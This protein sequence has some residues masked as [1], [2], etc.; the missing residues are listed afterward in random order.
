MTLRSLL[1]DFNS[2]FASVEQQAEPRLRGRPVGVVP[3][4]ADTTVCIAASIEAKTFGVKTGTRVGE[5]KR[6]CP[7]IELV[8]ARHALYIDYHH[9][10]VAAVDT[11]VPVRQ[12][13]S[14]DEMDCE[15]TGRWRERDR[16]LGLAREVKRVLREQVGECLRTSIGIGPNTFIAKTASDMVKPDGLVVIEQ[17]ELPQRLFGLALRD[18]SGIGPR[19]ERRLA[20]H[21]IRTV[22]AL[23][24]RSRDELRAVWG[25]VGGEVMHDRLRGEAVS[26]RDTDM[27]S[28]SHSSVLAPDRRN[29]EDAFAILD[30]LVQKAAV[31]LRKA[32]H[33][34]CRLSI[35]LKYLDGTR[36]D[37]DLRLVDTQD[38]V[39]FLH[40]LVRLWSGR[41]RD[42]RTILQVGMAFS[43]LVPESGRSGSLFAAESKSKALYATLDR[44]N[45]RFGRQAVYFA[46]AHKARDRG[47]M[48][49]AFNH[50][51]D[52]ET[53]R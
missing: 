46:S 50:I 10:A 8:V 31:R 22:Q 4:L 24:A 42:R 5:A 3:M 45:A 39:T 17:A 15:L 29:P 1:V 41:P 44:L 2:Y 9:R 25:G 43:D 35:G 32:G 12:V 51:P 47:G 19:M 14:I 16:A 38:T 30:R 21:G 49:I 23:C 28:I 36:W 33:Y 6:L 40:A 37:A 27:H 18:L 13:L 34:A 26:A 7:G 52:P 53:E 11:V 20:Q 48:H